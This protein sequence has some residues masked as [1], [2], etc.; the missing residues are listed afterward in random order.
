[1]SRFKIQPEREETA[2]V[3]VGQFAPEQF[4]PQWFAAN[5]L[6]GAADAKNATVYGVTPTVTRFEISSMTITVEQKRFM[7]AASVFSEAAFD[8][9]LNVFETVLPDRKSVV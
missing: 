8:L 2:V 1:M 6:I 4:H 3:F 5:E 9:T 7:V